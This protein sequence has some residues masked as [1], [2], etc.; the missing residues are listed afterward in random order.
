MTA[1]L[2]TFIFLFFILFSRLP[3]EEAGGLADAQRRK[4]N[5]KVITHDRKF[6]E[7]IRKHSMHSYSYLLH[8]GEYHVCTVRLYVIQYKWYIRKEVFIRSMIRIRFIDGIS[9]FYFVSVEIRSSD[10]CMSARTV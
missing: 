6:P 7:S 3:T 9:F 10:L 8:A 5:G 1:R 2:A 4:K